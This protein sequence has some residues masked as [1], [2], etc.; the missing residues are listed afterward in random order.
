MDDDDVDAEGNAESADS[1]T[2]DE[3]SGEKEMKP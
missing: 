2:A 3:P 1:E